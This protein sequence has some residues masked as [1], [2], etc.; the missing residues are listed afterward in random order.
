[1]SSQQAAIL[2]SI[3]LL[4]VGFWGYAANDF[5]VHTAI[6]PIGS[7]ILFLI[8]SQFLKYQ[9]K[10]FLLFMMAVTLILSIAFVV[11]FQRNLEQGDYLGMLRLG[12]EIAACI[13][14]FIVYLR[15]LIQLYKAKTS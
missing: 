14:A 13:L 1:M 6:V 9:N 4:L 2:N 7:G 5:A 3:V 10:L 15:N 8:L 12:L 11:P